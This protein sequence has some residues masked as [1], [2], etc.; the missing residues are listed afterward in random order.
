ME[1][2]D[3]IRQQNASLLLAKADT[4]VNSTV[5]ISLKEIHSLQ[6]NLNFGPYISRA[7][8]QCIKGQE[9]DLKGGGGANRST[10]ITTDINRTKQIIYT[11]VGPDRQQPSKKHEESIHLLRSL[12]ATKTANK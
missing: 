6:S 11:E 7:R 8:I 1:C 12:H 5:N 2:Q 9:H 4:A 3:L 10:P